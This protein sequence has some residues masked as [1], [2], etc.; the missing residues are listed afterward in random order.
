[1]GTG[2]VA[3]NI[4]LGMRLSGRGE[5]KLKMENPRTKSFKCHAQ[6]TMYG[7]KCIAE[8]DR[9]FVFANLIQPSVVTE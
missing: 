7:G 4:R 1:M 8:Q 3:R 5:I 2:A 6:K 9:I